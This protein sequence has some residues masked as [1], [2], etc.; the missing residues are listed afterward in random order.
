VTLR[1]PDIF[2]EA[3]DTLGGRNVDGK[4]TAYI[5]VDHPTEQ[6]E[7]MCSGGTGVRWR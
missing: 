7:F 5:I 4:L 1:V 3:T 6:R 2:L